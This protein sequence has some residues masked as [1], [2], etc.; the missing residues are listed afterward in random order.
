MF[1]S[2]RCCCGVQSIKGWHQLVKTLAAHAPEM[3]QQIAAQVMGR[4][5][6]ILYIKPSKDAHTQQTPASTTAVTTRVSSNNSTHRTARNTSTSASSPRAS[7]SAEDSDGAARSLAGR[8]AEQI[9]AIELL[10]ELVVINGGVLGENVLQR[11]P[12][13]PDDIDLPELL[14]IRLVSVAPV[15][16]FQQ[17][18][19]SDHPEKPFICII[20]RRDYRI[21]VSPKDF[22]FFL[23]KKNQLVGS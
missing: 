13:L 4:L 9:A 5:L 18:H 16:L 17:K 10:H 3:L 22:T 20:K 19:R 7:S 21:K 8:M 6:P 1:N 14:P 15:V 23:S 12:P 11:L 2:K